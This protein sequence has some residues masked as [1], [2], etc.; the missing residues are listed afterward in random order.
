M[1]VFFFLFLL[2]EKCFM[3]RRYYVPVYPTVL[4]VPTKTP[5]SSSLA[6]RCPR[7]TAAKHYFAGA[8][9]AVQLFHIFRF[10][11]VRY[12]EPLLLVSSSSCAP[13]PLLGNCWP[14]TTFAPSPT[15][16]SQGSPAQM[17]I[18]VCPPVSFSRQCSAGTRRIH[19]PHP[20]ALRTPPGTV[21]SPHA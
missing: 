17:L 11:N 8:A 20:Q 16:I 4:D 3:H 13:A 10:L 2:R 14:Q 21:V 15:L 12:G 5:T 6:F 7:G 9:S 1:C 18:P 19:V